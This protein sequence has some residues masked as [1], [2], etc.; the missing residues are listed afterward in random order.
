MSTS[1]YP[2]RVDAALDPQLSRGLWLVKWILVIPHYVAL[3]FLWAAFV[4]LS[5]VAFVAILVNGRYPRAVFDFNVGVLRWSWR[6]AYYAYGA[7]GTDRYPP[8]TL[9]DVSDYPAR[10]EVDYPEHL[11]RGLA[12]VKWWLLAIPHYLVVGVFLGG[13]V[14]VAN[15][16]V[17][18]EQVPWIW[19]G[20]LIGLL[21]LVAAVMLLVTGRY[22]RDVFDIVLGMNRWVLRVAA[23]A[24]LMTDQYP[25]FRFDQGGSDP[26]TRPVVAT[27]P[28]DRTSSPAAGPGGG[29]APA[30]W[31]T[32][33]IIA[34]VTGSVLLL[35]SGGL[36]AAG[37]G[38]TVADR[39]ARDASGFV[40]SG[41]QTFST[42]GYAIT[43]EN[44]EVHVDG[45]AAW[46]P[47]T[48]LGDTRVTATAAPGSEVFVGVGP[49]AQVREYLADVPHSVVVDRADGDLGYR[50]T[51]GT[52]QP[53]APVDLALWSAQSSGG[54]EHVLT[55][56]PEDGDWT[57]VLMNADGTRGVA[58]DITVA[59]ELPA[60]STAVAVLLSVGGTLLVFSLVVIAVAVPR[61]SRQQVAS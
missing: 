41:T 32:S 49:T 5:F 13:G 9:S 52:G 36:I 50:T 57:L 59:A 40:T 6:V 30:G 38:L 16:A 21:V 61:G 7:L 27:S 60:L 55:W 43:S 39:A 14:Y 51:G 35:V 22:P 18:S 48:L 42:D 12:L 34:L 2:V 46:V 26:G 10:L 45:A 3:V 29:H 1:S 33:R 54:K 11:S 25:P 44:L 8:F 47:E 31:S 37:V 53:A 15:E 56:T 4:V 28:P 19:G 17:T 20:G 24:G 58:A 23:Y